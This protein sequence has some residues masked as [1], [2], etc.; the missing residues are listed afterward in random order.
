MDTLIN[1]ETLR[2]KSLKG[3]CQNIFVKRKKKK[4]TCEK[5]VMKRSEQGKKNKQL[6][7]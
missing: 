7:N 5:G 3:G 4:E 6:G 1:V 2:Q